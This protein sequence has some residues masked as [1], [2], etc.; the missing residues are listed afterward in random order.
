[1]CGGSYTSVDLVLFGSI[2]DTIFDF[3]FL[4]LELYHMVDPST[5]QCPLLVFGVSLLIKGPVQ[6]QFQL[7]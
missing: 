3:I 1:M 2:F 5:V 6:S 7:L 4:D